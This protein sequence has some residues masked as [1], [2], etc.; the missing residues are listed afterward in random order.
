MPENKNVLE[1]ENLLE[2]ITRHVFLVVL[3]ISWPKLSYQIS[4]AV[5]AI[6]GHDDEKTEVA[7]DLRTNPQWQLMPPEWRR[8]L[9]NLESRARSLLAGTS[10]QFAARG[11]AVL[12][13][14]RAAAIFSGLRELREELHRDRDEFV[15]SYEQVLASLKER[16]G[17]ELYKKVAV[18]LPSKS[19]I[20]NKFK[21]VWAIV[22][23]GGHRGIS[24]TQ[25][26]ILQRS[27]D[28]SQRVID[29]EPINIAINEALETVTELRRN[30]RPTTIDDDD[31]SDL[32]GEARQQMNQFTNQMLEDMAREPREMLAAAADNLLEAL[33][34]PVR[35]IRTGTIEQVRRAFEVV[36]GFSFIADDELIERMRQCQL[37][38]D[39][40][41]PQQLNSDTEIGGRIA[42][43]LQSV[44]E[45][46][47]DATASADAVRNFRR[48]KFRKGRKELNDEPV[49]V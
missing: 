20:R 8:R 44:K 48:V 39:N 14:T 11:M 24:E 35:I 3:N 32:I 23:A 34:D 49:V 6:K 30:S 27:L 5:V 18:K 25:L 9:A 15:V 46:A 21:M 7:A 22:P 36:Q 1:D 45:Q 31:A 10:I 17:D 47:S 33:R 40:V 19:A 13:V 12:P 38:L 43:G 37:R 2:Q 41:T 4:D 26:N 29:S 16:L 42:A 28:M